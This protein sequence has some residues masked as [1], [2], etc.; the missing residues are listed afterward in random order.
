[1][2][3]LAKHRTAR[4]VAAGQGVD[5]AVY[6]ILM[7]LY[8]HSAKCGGRKL[9]IRKPSIHAGCSP[10]SALSTLSTAQRTE[11]ARATPDKA[12]VAPR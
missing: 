9:R 4:V 6:G 5:R 3:R 11:Q 8:P 2:M 7:A 10:F 1:M 12:G